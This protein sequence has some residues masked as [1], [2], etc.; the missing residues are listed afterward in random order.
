MKDLEAKYGNI[1]QIQDEAV[2]TKA[3]A[4]REAVN[5]KFPQVQ[6]NVQ[7][8]VDHI[9]HVRKVVGV[10]Y[11]G[12]G[13]DFDGGGGVVGCDDV[14]GMIH[15][16]EELVRRGYTDREIEKIWG[17]NFLRVFQKVIDLAGK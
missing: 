3:M 9:D 4:E 16:T 15:V 7:D 10:D 17:G 2:R 8:L 14:S 11:V 13:T 12:I 1:R 5:Q 6:A